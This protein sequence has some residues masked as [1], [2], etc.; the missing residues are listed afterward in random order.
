VALVCYSFGIK[1][2]LYEENMSWIMP[3]T[4]IL[5]LLITPAVM[6][7]SPEKS[8]TILIVGGAGYIGSHTNEMLHRKGYQT[9]VLDSLEEGHRETVLH[10]TFV[11]GNIGDSTTLD[12][13]FKSYQIAAVMHFAAYKDVGESVVDPMK[14]YWNNVANTLTLLNA[15]Q[16]HN[17]NHLIFSSSAGVFGQP[18]EIPITEEHSCNPISP[19]GKTKLMIE[20]I[21]HDFDTAYGLRYMSLRYFNAAGGDPEGK[22][23]NYKVKDCNI[24]PILLN[25]VRDPNQEFTIFGTDYPTDDGTC[26]RD[27]I[28]IEDIGTAH[29]LALEKLLRGSPSQSYNLGNGTGFSVRQVIASVERVTGCKIKINE[30]KRRSGDPPILVASSKKA[31]QELNWTPAYPSLETMIEHAWQA[32][33]Q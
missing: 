24:I 25:C 23:K 5:A 22:L 20:H 12:R 9:I 11:Q 10:G 14:Y 19:Y 29:L 13:I 28:H 17:V 2:D 8:K 7:S 26:I 30:G 15:M 32:L 6:H 1:I 31:Q 27:F 4:W 16:R 21:L 3:V 18:K 33:S